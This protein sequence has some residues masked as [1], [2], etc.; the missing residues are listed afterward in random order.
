[1]DEKTSRIN[2]MSKDLFKKLSDEFG[3]NVRFEQDLKKRLGLILV[4]NQR[5]F[6]KLTI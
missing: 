4:E 5:Y 2:E 3:S 6:I 1:M